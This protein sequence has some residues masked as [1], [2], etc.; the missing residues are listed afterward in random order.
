MAMKFAIARCSTKEQ[1][2]ARQV[3][4]LLA[5]GVSQENIFI[6]KISGVAKVRPVLEDVMS[7]LREGDELIICDL[8]RL[9][10][11]TKQL[12][13]TVDALTDKGVTLVSLKENLDLS[14]PVGRM[15][16]TVLMSVVQWQ[17]E[18]IIDNCQM[19]RET[20]KSKGKSLGGR[21]RIS[22]KTYDKAI[23]LYQSGSTVRE[24]KE[25]TGVSSP[26]LYREL[27]RRGLGR[28]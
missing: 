23:A 13:E 10:R 9:A 7:R 1:D 15:T 2:E 3:D 6:E 8:S 20:A 28:S 18:M 16:I 24:V 12:L 14:T 19:G 4:A 17:R 21:P 25:L 11:S 5:H 22:P 26:S 27:E